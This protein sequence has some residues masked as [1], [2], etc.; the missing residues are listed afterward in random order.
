MEDRGYVLETEEGLRVT[1]R[2]AVE[3]EAGRVYHI[4][5]DPED[6]R[7]IASFQCQKWL[8]YGEVIVETR[9]VADN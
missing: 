8:S 2:I 7:V 3:E 6:D 5:I 1:V 9:D 4:F